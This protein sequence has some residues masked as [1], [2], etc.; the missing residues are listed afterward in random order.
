MTGPLFHEVLQKNY[1]S[2]TAIACCGQLFTFSIK[3]LMITTLY[4]SS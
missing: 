1:I 4:G 2:V 3:H